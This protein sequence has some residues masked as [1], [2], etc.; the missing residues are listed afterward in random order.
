MNIF[1]KILYI[2][3]SEMTSPTNYSWFH[4]LFLLIVIGCTIFLCIHFKDCTEKTFNKIMLISW[5]VIVVL[6]IY[7]QIIFT[8][9]YSDGVVE[10]DYAWYSF[11]YQ[12]CSSP[13]YVLPFIIFLKEGKLKDAFISFMSTFVLFAGIA[14]M[15]YPN[16][17]FCATIGINIQTMIH[18]GLQVVLGIFCIVYNR[19]KYDLQY[20][21]KALYVFIPIIVIAMILN[22][23]VYHIFQANNI[24]DTF[25]MFYISPYFDCT[26]PVL[27]L[28]Y[29]KVPYIVFLFIYV[30]GF[31]IINF[32]FHYASKFIINLTRKK[33]LS[34]NQ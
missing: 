31:S 27:S 16:D 24:D 2:L 29:P 11:P 32:I 19:D 28:I 3:D 4:I 15:L 34:A 20:G 18:H 7:K 17:V 23:S 33:K 21:L 12:F 13:I 30:I 14:V 25:N 8:F 9:E 26:L 5:I 22:I 6:E 1:E 10:W